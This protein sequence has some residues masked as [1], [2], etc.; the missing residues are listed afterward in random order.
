MKHTALDFRSDTVTRPTRAM[1]EAMAAAEVGDDVMQEDPTINLLEERVAAFFG[2]EAALFVPTGT[3]ANLIA[4]ALH[5][6]RGEEIVLERR[7][8]CLAHE[9]VSAAAVVGASYWPVDCPDGRLRAE[10]VLGALRFEDVHHPRTRLV[11][12][13]NTVNIAGGLVR[14]PEEIAEVR[15]LCLDKGLRLHLDGARIWNALSA[16][17]WSGETFGGLCDTLSCCLSKGMGCPAGSLLV[18]D[19]AAIDEG[20]RHRKMLGGG[21]RQAGILAA[22]GLH[23]LEHEFPRLGE[24]HA[25]ARSLAE[26]LAGDTRAGWTVRNPESNMVFLDHADNAACLA[27]VE[28]LNGLGILCWDVSPTEIRLVCHRDLPADAAEQMAAR[29]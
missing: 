2:R 12:L 29:L 16:G 25:L 19:R 14:S 4:I 22:A 3:M 27:N 8:H 17:G 18:G 15:Q 20:R 28:R 23:A 1:R 21:M 9:A 5:C 11:V 24:D 13:E 26:V 7:T 10:H 6:R